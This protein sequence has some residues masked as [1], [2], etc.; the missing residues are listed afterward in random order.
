[1]PLVRVSNGGSVPCEI[2]T[3]TGVTTGTIVN[4]P[5][6]NSYATKP[7]VFIVVKNL[8]DGGYADFLTE[9]DFNKT[10]SNYTGLMVKRDGMSGHRSS[11]MTIYVSE[12]NP[13]V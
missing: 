9:F 11:N 3:V 10:G 12:R 6:A 13:F 4:V 2:H 5:F 1:M 7:N 8:Y